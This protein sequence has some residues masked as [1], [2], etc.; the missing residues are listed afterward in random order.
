MHEIIK[1]YIKNFNF[2][3]KNTQHG[4]VK[5]RLVNDGE[6]ICIGI[7]EVAFGRA[8]GADPTLE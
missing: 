6:F 8:V 4:S 3:Q 7:A 1:N 5:I 2:W